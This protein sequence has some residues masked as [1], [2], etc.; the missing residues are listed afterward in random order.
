M[1]EVQVLEAVNIAHA[2]VCEVLDLVDTRLVEAEAS[3]DQGTVQGYSLLSCCFP[4]SLWTFLSQF[5]LSLCSWLTSPSWQSHFHVFVLYF[6]LACHCCHC[7]GFVF[8][9]SS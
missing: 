8:N 4:C 5:S 9:T 6:F 2:I 3:A 1:K 7:Y